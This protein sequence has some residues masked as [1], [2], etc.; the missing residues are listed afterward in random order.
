MKFSVNELEAPEISP[1]VFIA[2]EGLPPGRFLKFEKPH[3]LLVATCPEDVLPCLQEAD[4]ALA[5]GHYL[6]GFI[7]YEASLG[8]DNAYVTSRAYAMPLIWLGVF[9]S[10]AQID[11]SEARSSG[12]AFRWEAEIS[13]DEY[14][15]AIREVRSRIARGFTYQANVTFRLLSSY[16][17]ETWDLFRFLYQNQ[18]A[19]SCAYVDTGRWA[20][21]SASPEI[22]FDLDRSSIRVQPM[23][24]T[25]RRGR[26]R[27]EDEL[28]AERLGTSEKD[29][30]ENLMIVDMIRNDL[31]R[32]CKVGS[33]RVPALFEVERLPT[34]FQ[35]TST[36]TGSTDASFSE[37]V[38]A[39]FPCASITG[40]PKVETMKIIAGVER[41]PREV[42][43][44]SIGYFTPERRAR[45]NVAIR[46]V[47]VDK[48]AGVAQCGIG[49]GVIWDST[50][51]AEYDECLLKS[52]FSVEQS[53]SFQL[54]ETLRHDP[55]SGF[56]LLKLHLRRLQ[57][58]ARFFGYHF[59]QGLVEE[60]L[61]SAV[62]KAE[63]VSLKIRILLSSV[64]AVTVDTAPLS[65]DPIP[66][67]AQVRFARE[68]ID[69]SDSMLFHKT[70]ERA[71]Y[72][73]MIG[74][75]PGSYDVILWNKEGFVTELTRFNIVV[76]VS[77][78]WKTPRVAH[79]LL[80][81][82][83]SQQLISDQLLE[84][85]DLTRAD[86]EG[87]ELVAVLNSVRGILILKPCDVGAWS[88][89]TLSEN[90]AGNPELV[91]LVDAVRQFVR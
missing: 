14:A 75:V 5:K 50:P 47:I 15:S 60:H 49:S 67:R 82:T 79:G 32:V 51:D 30:A 89:E 87:A 91:R 4:G 72:Q 35:M 59:E 1:T 77:G 69:V 33:V 48:K 18:P 78:R 83:L 24:G 9:S 42:Y 52:R 44:G 88:L 6:A 29:R 39:L 26:W 64:G 20:V 31:G 57:S 46:T 22:F 65:A 81:G 58:S 71:V 17:E 73:R 23:K 11:V 54:L 27:E 90:S 53:R 41:S 25:I 66:E 61:Q 74:S 10:P 16:F 2:D 8:L 13:R 34:L 40:A 36:V 80:K 56:A 76:S 28:L 45:F 19:S 3:A 63:R 85:G 62:E 21:C 12:V 68:P 43:T 86:I 84:E 37:I 38:S 55:E 70:T 7:S